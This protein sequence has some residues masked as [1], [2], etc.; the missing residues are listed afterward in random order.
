MEN[1]CDSSTGA[2]REE[3]GASMYC[4]ETVEYF[5]EGWVG[6]WRDISLFERY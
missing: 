5:W 4:R 1:A 3:V 6:S 2:V